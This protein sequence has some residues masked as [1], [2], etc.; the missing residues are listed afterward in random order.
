MKELVNVHNHDIAIIE[1]N[2]ERVLTTAQLAE[3]YETEVVNIK[4]NFGRNQGRF[5]E[6]IHYFLL[7]DQT[8]REF[9]NLVT[10]SPL[11]DK[12]TPQ[13]Y[14]WTRRGASR[15]CK[16]LDTDKAWE[17]F[18]YLEK[19]YFNSETKAFENLSV[20][21][22][23]VIAVDRRVTKVEKKINEVDRNLQEF[24]KD[25][26]LLG[27]ECDEIK[28]A[29]NRKVV[30]LLGG[31]NAAAYRDKSLRSRV[32]I[33]INN[34]LCREFGVSVYAAIKRCQTETAKKIIE[35]YKLPLALEEEIKNVNNQLEIHFKRED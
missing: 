16:I 13:L 19:A 1:W 12:H 18:D 34:Q 24:K 21:L 28:K 8:L 26:P 33:D 5:K 31:K 29:K 10:D 4:K 25:L 23:A 6:N 27:V 7:K 9:K 2:G 35:E 15:H 11:V 30:P 17:Q 3:V 14:L 22:Q 20:E 32:Y